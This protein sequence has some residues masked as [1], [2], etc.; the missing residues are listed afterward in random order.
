MCPFAGTG[1][2]CNCTGECR[3]PDLPYE[4][5]ELNDTVPIVLV[6]CEHTDS[7]WCPRCAGGLE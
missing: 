3:E 7:P 1:L 6:V 5:R 4:P 2:A